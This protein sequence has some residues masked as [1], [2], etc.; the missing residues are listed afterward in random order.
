MMHKCNPL[1]TYSYIQYLH[2]KFTIDISTVNFSEHIHPLI[3]PYAFSVYKKVSHKIK[4]L[5][6][7]AIVKFPQNMGCSEEFSRH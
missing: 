7:T 2:V 4:M 3:S 5:I 6:H 1:H